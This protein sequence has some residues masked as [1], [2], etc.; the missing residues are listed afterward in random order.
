MGTTPEYTKKAI[1][2]YNSKFDRVAVNLPKGTKEKIKNLTGKSC[3]AFVSELVVNEIKNIEKQKFNYDISAEQADDYDPYTI[4]GP[5][6]DEALGLNKI[7]KK[8]FP[9]M[10]IEEMA[11]SM[12]SSR[13][14]VD[15]RYQLK[16]MDQFGIENVKKYCD[17]L[18]QEE[19]RKKLIDD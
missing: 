18:K 12:D 6:A 5:E 10:T 11:E 17:H 1:K 3:N 4:D 2:N 13:I 14:S 15:S 8:V 9:E 19:L 7:P 16:M